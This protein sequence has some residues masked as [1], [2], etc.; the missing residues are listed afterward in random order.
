MSKSV[1][2]VCQ[3]TEF[4][5]S[6]TKVLGVYLWLEEAV[7]KVSRLRGIGEM[8]QGSFGSFWKTQSGLRFYIRSFDL[9]EQRDMTHRGKSV[10]VAP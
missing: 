3:D 8:Q 1:Y 4:Y 7:Q 10:T 5:S 9:G 2:L 6:E